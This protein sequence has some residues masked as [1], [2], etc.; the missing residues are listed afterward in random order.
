MINYAFKAARQRSEFY[1]FYRYRRVLVRSAMQKLE[2]G[3][4][5]AG[6]RYNHIK[7]VAFC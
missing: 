6:Y 1:F 7:F 4:L 5:R 3:A 2:G